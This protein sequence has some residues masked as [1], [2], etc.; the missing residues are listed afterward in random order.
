MMSCGLDYD[1]PCQTI[2]FGIALVLFVVGLKLDVRIIRDTGRVAVV[3]G[4][5]QIALTGA[6]GFGLA[7]L[8]GLGVDELS[9][10]PYSV[11]PIKQSVR[12][13][14]MARCRELA[15]RALSLPSADEVR[16]LVD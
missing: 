5:A 10:A 3:T 8:L 7:L 2:T 6:I 16:A 14:S 15:R 4:G 12:G 9:V 13:L 11:P 1:D